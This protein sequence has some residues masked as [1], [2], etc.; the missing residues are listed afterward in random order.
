MSDK[1]GGLMGRYR[2]HCPEFGFFNFAASLTSRAEAFVKMRNI[3]PLPTA[4]QK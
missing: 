3:M 4:P 1:S 2:E